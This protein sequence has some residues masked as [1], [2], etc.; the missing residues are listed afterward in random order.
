MTTA[1]DNI[2]DDQYVYDEQSHGSHDGEPD[3]GSGS[4]TGSGAHGMVV[5]VA[6]PV[7]YASEGEIRQ[8]DCPHYQILRQ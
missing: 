3:V 7:V 5:G 6:A 4:T 2:M 8:Q 1:S